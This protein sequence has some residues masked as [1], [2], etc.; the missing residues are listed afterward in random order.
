MIIYKYLIGMVIGV[1]IGFT[2]CWFYYRHSITNYAIDPLYSQILKHT[3]T[4]TLARSGAY[5][6]LIADRELDLAVTIDVVAQL[7]SGHPLSERRRKVLLAAN[8]Y[9]E[10]YP[11]NTEDT[12]M[13]QN[14]SMFLSKVRT[15]QAGAAH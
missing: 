5:D 10:K 11:I 13:N 2:S 9:Y 8:R 1:V 4:L 15:V 7:Q 14:V 6:R 12:N 3:S